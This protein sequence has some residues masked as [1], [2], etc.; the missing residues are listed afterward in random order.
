LVRKKCILT[1]YMAGISGNLL[2]TNCS[3]ISKNK[4]VNVIGE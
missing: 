2:K 3:L 4:P 1:D